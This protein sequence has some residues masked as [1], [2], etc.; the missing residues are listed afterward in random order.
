MVRYWQ[1][2]KQFKVAAASGGGAGRTRDNKEIKGITEE[3]R[4]KQI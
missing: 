1:Y 2:T 3:G 4:N